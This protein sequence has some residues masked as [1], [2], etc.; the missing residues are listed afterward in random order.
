[1]ETKFKAAIEE[2]IKKTKRPN[3][4]SFVNSNLDFVIQNS[5]RGVPL[6][7]FWETSFKNTLNDLGIS[8]KGREPNVDWGNIALKAMEINSEVLDPE[9]STTSTPPSIPKGIKRGSKTASCSLTTKEKEKLVGFVQKMSPSD[10]WVFTRDDGSQAFVEDQLIEY[11]EK[12]DYE[13]HSLILN[14]DDPVW[15]S[16]FSEREMREISRKGVTSLPSLPSSIDNI[17]SSCT[18]I[19]EEITSKDQQKDQDKE[20]V[21]T[22]TNY[23]EKLAPFDPYD[24]FDEYW[25]ISTLKEIC[26]LY[27]WNIP[28]RIANGSSELDFVVRIWSQ[29]DKCFD[30]LDNSCLANLVR[31]N[32]ERRV[33]GKTPISDQVKSSR[34][35]LL[36]TK[37]NVEFGVGE[38]G[39]IDLGGIGKKEIL[40]TQLHLPKLMK[41]VFTIEQ[42]L[43]QEMMLNLHESFKLLGLATPVSFRMTLSVMDCPDG[44]VCRLRES[45]EF[46][47]PQHASL[48]CTGII[49]IIELTLMAKSGIDGYSK[50]CITYGGVW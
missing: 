39:K 3:L 25:L 35:D 15:E 24:Q 14:V 16:F 8:S 11:T 17:L 36:L 6:Q 37:D 44:V 48:F 7:Q 22:L 5:P 4:A 43:R 12:C 34:P 32:N 9:S 42:Y 38:C 28:S 49:P 40:E 33:D 26:S 10:K 13:H 29:L 23:L 50:F 18:A 47:I 1:M 30:N 45:E 41:D 31:L 20:I 46:E 21:D 2:L 27:R 19:V